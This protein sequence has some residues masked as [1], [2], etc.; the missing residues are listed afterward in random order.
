VNPKEVAK[1][2][3]TQVADDYSSSSSSVRLPKNS[4][5]LDKKDDVAFVATKKKETEALDQALADRIGHRLALASH[6][7][8]PSDGALVPSALD[9]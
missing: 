3:P 2:Q 8:F 7:S 4:K 9:L 6:P 5:L 1:P